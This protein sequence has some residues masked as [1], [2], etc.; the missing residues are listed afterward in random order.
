MKDYPI[1]PP[2]PPSYMQIVIDFNKWQIDND[3][4]L[5]TLD[6]NTAIDTFRTEWKRLVNIYLNYMLDKFNRELSDH[7]I[8]K[9]NNAK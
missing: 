2:K 8:T 7:H 1:P 3:K 9:Y 6:T 4:L 5:R